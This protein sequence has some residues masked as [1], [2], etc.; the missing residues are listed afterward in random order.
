MKAKPKSLE[1]NVKA[2]VTKVSGGEVDAGIG[3]VTD[4]KAAAASVEGVDISDEYNVVAEYPMAV[5]KQS[6][7]AALASAFLDFVLNPDSQ[8][9][10]AKYGFVAV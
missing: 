3:Y 9:V 6:G 4:A 8:A 5:L 10:L 1:T 2:V 7:N